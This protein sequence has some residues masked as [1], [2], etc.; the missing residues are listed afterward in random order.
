MKK[1]EIEMSEPAYAVATEMAR[2]A[3]RGLFAVELE[4][5]ASVVWNLTAKCRRVVAPIARKFGLSVKRFIEKST[6][7]ELPGQVTRNCDKARDVKMPKGFGATNCPPELWQ[8][9]Q[10]AAAFSEQTP[11]AF[12]WGATMGTVDSCECD[13]IVNPK[14]AQ[15]TIG[16]RMRLEEFQVERSHAQRA[17]GMRSDIE[18][19]I[20]RLQSFVRQRFGR[21]VV[22]DSGAAML[23]ISHDGC[24]LTNS[25][26]RVIAESVGSIARQLTA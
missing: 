7:G 24:N 10:R 19:A 13:M 11:E 8:R 6:R 18:D 25:N 22:T 1:I 26:S 20:M 2:R 21:K 5:G 16:D 12:I 15:Q 3:D 23:F 14:N 9:I 17:A 4:S